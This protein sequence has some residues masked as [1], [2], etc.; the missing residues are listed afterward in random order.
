MRIETLG[1]STRVMVSLARSARPRVLSPN[2]LAVGD[3][4]GRSAKIE[5]QRHRPTLLMTV[6]DRTSSRVPVSQARR[7]GKLEDDLTWHATSGYV[8]ADLETQDS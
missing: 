4:S 8:P 6:S 7:F 2:V 1:A 5:Q 3:G